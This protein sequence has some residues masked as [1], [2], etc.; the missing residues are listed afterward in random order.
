MAPEARRPNSSEPQPY[1]GISAQHSTATSTE[2]GDN[3]TDQG[4]GCRR[5]ELAGSGPV[6]SRRRGGSRPGGEYRS[7]KERTRVEERV[8]E[9]QQQPG[10][11]LVL[12]G[13]LLLL[14][15]RTQRWG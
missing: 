9:D 12:R 10:G 4:R 15:H 8:G 3:E 11:R 5:P 6:R 14:L 7:A 2:R 1:K 13:R